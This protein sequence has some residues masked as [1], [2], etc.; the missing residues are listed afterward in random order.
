MGVKDHDLYLDGSD[1][2]AMETSTTINQH[3][4]IHTQTSNF[5]FGDQ[6]VEIHQSAILL[7]FWA[8]EKLPVFKK[9]VHCCPFAENS[10]G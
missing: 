7:V 8:A 2:P 4:T 3:T 5:E 6:I 9:F 1:N 10:M